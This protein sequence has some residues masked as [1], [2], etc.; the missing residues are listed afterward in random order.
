LFDE[1]NELTPFSPSNRLSLKL[2]PP[3][4][5]L[6]KSA[7]AVYDNKSHTNQ[8]TFYI[9]PSNNASDESLEVLAAGPESH[10]GNAIKCHRPNQ[11]S[12]LTNL[13]AQN[14]VSSASSRQFVPTH[15]K[16]LSLGSN[17]NAI[18][19][20]L[21]L[22]DSFRKPD[23]KYSK[24]YIVDD[25][26]VE[27]EFDC[28]DQLCADHPELSKITCDSLSTSVDVYTDSAPEEDAISATA[29]SV[30]DIHF[31]DSRSHPSSVQNHHH[32]HHPH[33]H[34][35]SQPPNSFDSN[36]SEQTNFLASNAHHSHLH[37]LSTHHLH[38]NEYIAAGHGNRTFIASNSTL[39]TADLNCEYGSSVPRNNF[40][41][42]ILYQGFIR[43]KTILKDGKRPTLSTWM[44][45]WLVLNPSS[46]IFYS[47]KSLRGCYRS[48]FKSQPS[49]CQSLRSTMIHVKPDEGSYQM[50]IFVLTDPSSNS[51]Y[52][53]K[54]NTQLEAIT[55]C[56]EIS[57][58][59]LKNSKLTEQS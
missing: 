22:A 15:R 1:A 25:S 26:L 3:E 55:W 51:M 36:C 8:S 38:H 35:H 14:S 4:S 31:P 45:Y 9:S 12:D 58:V 47:S 30:S 29:I 32:H 16:S 44:R 56:R 23:V 53:F 43:R 46:L 10:S 50:D 59:L 6:S 2:E 37:H 17:S 39:G 41:V 24:R 27:E 52:K 28:V 33:S 5:K 21:F 7:K 18:A 11:V 13:S 42:N 19:N 54:T 34:V 48:H 57:N 20:R 49:K 40:I